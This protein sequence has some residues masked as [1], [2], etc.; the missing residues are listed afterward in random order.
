ML[1]LEAIYGDKIHIF[2]EKAG[3]RSFQVQL[4]LFCIQLVPRSQESVTIIETQNHDTVILIFNS[5]QIQVHCEIP[6]GISVCAE[7]SQGV[8]DDD[9]S[10]KF[11]DN[12]SVEHLAPLSLT[13]LMPPS[14]PS[15]YPP[16]FTLGVQWLDNVKVSALCQMLDSI[17]AQQPGQEVVYEW[18]QWLQTS[19][20]SHLGF[21]DRIV[22]Q[23][24]DDSMVG[25]VDVRVIG[26]ILSVE[27]VIQRL[28][29]YNEE[30]SHESFLRDLHACMICYSVCTMSP[31]RTNTTPNNSTQKT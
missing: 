26:E 1:A 28:I 16:Y 11:L 5:L 3:L 2:D 22:I 10:S 6:D 4:F 30:Q 13:C 27:D 9:P 29:S 18:V 25:P 14:Y 19:T 24:L 15:D 8:D 31:R 7:S 20:L 17:W 12:F 23:Q 21:D